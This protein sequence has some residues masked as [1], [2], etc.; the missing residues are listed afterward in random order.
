[1]IFPL[2][3]NLSYRLTKENKQDTVEKISVIHE[4]LT[5]TH[6]IYFAIQNTL[7]RNLIYFVMQ[8]NI[9]WYII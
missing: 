2:Y 3:L 7:D 5:H 4:S 1:M 6:G 9:F 8:S